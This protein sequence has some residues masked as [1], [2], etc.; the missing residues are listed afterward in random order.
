MLVGMLSLSGGSLECSHALVLARW[1]S[2]HSFLLFDARATIYFY[3]DQVV[4]E[5]IHPTPCKWVTSS[6]VTSSSRE[7]LSGARPRL[8]A[9]N[10]TALSFDISL[11][12]S[13]EMRQEEEEVQP[14]GMVE[15]ASPL[16]CRE[17]ASKLVCVR[18]VYCIA[19]MHPILQHLWKYRQ[20]KRPLVQGGQP[21]AM[22]MRMQMHAIEADGKK[23]EAIEACRDGLEATSREEDEELFSFVTKI[24]VTAPAVPDLETVVHICAKHP[25]KVL[26]L[27]AESEAERGDEGEGTCGGGGGS[28]H[29]VVEVG[30]WHAVSFRIRRRGCCLPHHPYH[31]AFK[32]KMSWQDNTICI[33]MRMFGPPT[34]VADF[35]DWRRARRRRRRRIPC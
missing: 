12:L 31:T 13:S 1:C 7:G 33:F 8:K 25:E 9:G 28:E 23:A 10:T 14:V 32:L 29:A 18:I 3:F 15:R 24:Q 4:E 5:E 17:R 20:N 35:E 27:S 16:V 6:C 22:R 11:P 34:S 21:E 26:P 19:G 2:L 30:A